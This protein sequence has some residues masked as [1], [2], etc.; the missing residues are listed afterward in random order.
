[1]RDDDDNE[2]GQDDGDRGDDSAGEGV[3][4]HYDEEEDDDDDPFGGFLGRHGGPAGL[5][6]T[7]RA[8]SG[9]MSGMSSHSQM[10]S[11]LENLRQKD[12][13]MVQVEALGTLNNILLV[14]PG[15]DLAGHFQPD[16]FVR[17]LV[18]LMQPNEFALDGQ[19]S[20]EQITLACQC[21][22]N[23]VDNLPATTANVVYGGAVPVLCQKLKSLNTPEGFF[24]ID[25]AEHALSVSFSR[26]TRR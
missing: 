17:E 19:E 7:L 21:I 4:P 20:V 10:R 25:A 18:T 8:L 1:M 15:E 11:I 24:Y 13:P 2:E 9:M 26:L 5:S 16:Q 12:N 3:P 22:A 14:T 6:S 23:M